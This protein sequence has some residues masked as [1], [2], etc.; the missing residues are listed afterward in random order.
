WARETSA[1]LGYNW[2]RQDSPS[3]FSFGI[4]QAEAEAAQDQG[5]EGDQNFALYSA[6]PGTLQRMPIYLYPT[7]SRAVGAL[8]QPPACSRA[9]PTRR[10]PIWKC[11]R[12]LASRSLRRSMAA[13]PPTLLA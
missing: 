11:S 1:N 5:E 8:D 3:S 4:R 6:R 7:L 10:S 13:A 9:D 2:Y 12:R